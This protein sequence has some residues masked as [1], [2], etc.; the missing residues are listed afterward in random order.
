MRDVGGGRGQRGCQRVVA[1]IGTAQ[2]DAADVD[3][4]AC[5][6]VFVAEGSGGG[7]GGQYIATVLA[8]KGGSAG[9]ERGQGIAVIGL[10][11]SRDAGDVCNRCRRD[12]VVRTGVDDGV[13]QLVGQSTLRDGVAAQDIFAASAGQRTGQRRC[14]GVTINQGRCAVGERGQRGVIDLGAGVRGHGQ[15]GLDAVDKCA[16]S[17]CGR[18]G[19]VSV[20]TFAVAGDG[21]S[22]G[23][24]VA[25][26]NNVAPVDCRQTGRTNIVDELP[27]GR[28]TCRIGG[29]SLEYDGVAGGAG[30][31]CIGQGEVG[32]GAGSFDSS[33]A[34]CGDACCSAHNANRQCACLRVINTACTGCQR[35]D[36]ICCVPECV[37][38]ASTGQCKAGCG[39]AA[40]LGDCAAG[41]QRGVTGG[42]HRCHCKSVSVGVADG[43]RHIGRITGVA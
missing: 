1:G 23:R 13:A 3:G 17:P 12:G 9:I 33:N 15:R 41:R 35:G 38:T 30:R 22:R 26:I 5:A 19:G 4:L 42:G 31:H 40:R 10:A 37:G 20:V 27:A 29:A 7:G 36:R 24:R 28:N 39:D 6:C 32:G 8:G 34:C 16:G 18:V 25:R 11:G 43:T 21:L 14:N 2:G